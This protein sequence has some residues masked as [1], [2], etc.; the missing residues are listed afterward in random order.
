MEKLQKLP[1][2]KNIKI[3]STTSKTPDLTSKT[4]NIFYQHFFEKGP[5]LGVRHPK[6]IAD[7]IKQIK[8]TKSGH[9]HKKDST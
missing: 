5:R 2:N 4:K 6:N 3:W 9:Q 8:I 1:R 7:P